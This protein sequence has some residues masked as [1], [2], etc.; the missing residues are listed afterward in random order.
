MLFS[1][2]K[3]HSDNTLKNSIGGQSRVW[4]QLMSR[5]SH[6]KWKEYRIQATVGVKME[7]NLKSAQEMNLGEQ[8][9]GVRRTDLS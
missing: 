9:V 7:I 6:P 3:D 2:L 5:W 1:I 8:M 4:G